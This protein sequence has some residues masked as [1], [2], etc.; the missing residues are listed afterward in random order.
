MRF[1]YPPFFIFFQM[2]IASFDFFEIKFQ[3]VLKSSPYS[4]ETIF[5][6]K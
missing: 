2:R 5:E 4:L 6:L 3:N 1:A